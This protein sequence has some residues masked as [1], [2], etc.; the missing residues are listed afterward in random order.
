MRK[1]IVATWNADQDVDTEQPVKIRI[2][3]E[4]ADGWET[5]S[6]PCPP[7]LFAR[8][9]GNTQ[10]DPSIDYDG[11]GQEASVDFSYAFPDAA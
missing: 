1:R 2:V 3:T 7:E 10:S 6:V 11:R 5:E 9:D 4:D 8:I